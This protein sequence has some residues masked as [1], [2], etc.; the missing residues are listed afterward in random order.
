MLQTFE[1][2]ISREEHYS[3]CITCGFFFQSHL[4]IIKIMGEILQLMIKKGGAY[5]Y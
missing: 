3:G 2:N 4:E 1:K 5:I